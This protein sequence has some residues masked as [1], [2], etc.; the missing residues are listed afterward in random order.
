MSFFMIRFIDVRAQT[1]TPDSLNRL[2]ASCAD[3]ATIIGICGETKLENEEG[4]WWTM[5]Q[6]SFFLSLSFQS[7]G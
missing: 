6:V 7:E 5:I 4:S 1:V 3:D 2:V